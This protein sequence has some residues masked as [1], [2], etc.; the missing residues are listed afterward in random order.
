MFS[1]G[2]PIMILTISRAY[3]CPIIPGTIPTTPPSEQLVTHA[4]G[5]GFGYKHL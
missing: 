2:Y 1:L 4:A 5:G 3:I